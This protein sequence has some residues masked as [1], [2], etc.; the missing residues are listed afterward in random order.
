MDIQKTWEQD[1]K[2]DQ[3]III[4]YLYYGKAHFIVF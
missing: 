1:T 4:N 2:E 3:L